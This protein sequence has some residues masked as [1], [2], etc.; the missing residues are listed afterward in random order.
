[1]EKVRRA[2]VCILEVNLDSLYENQP[3]FKEIFLLLNELGYRYAGNLNQ[4]FS[5]EDGHII[6]IDAVF[7]K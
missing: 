7:V 3:S 4:A 5:K 6:F 2:K 1:M